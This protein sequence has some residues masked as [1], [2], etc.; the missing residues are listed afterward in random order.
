MKLNCAEY[1]LHRTSDCHV[2]GRAGWK[3]W[4]AGP[5][6]NNISV[7]LRD[8]YSIETQHEL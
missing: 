7:G 6:M 8:T 5:Y 4:Q 1:E 3:C 2:F